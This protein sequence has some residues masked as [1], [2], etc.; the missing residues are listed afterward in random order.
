MTPTLNSIWAFATAKGEGVAK[1]YVEAYK[2]WLAGGGAG[3]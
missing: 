1:D 2:W 3:R